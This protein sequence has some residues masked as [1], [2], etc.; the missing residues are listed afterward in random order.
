MGELAEYAYCPRAW[1]YR[2]HPPAEGPDPQ[3]LRRADAGRT[4]H[5]RRLRATRERER[6]EGRYWAALAAAAVSFAI[7]LG[8]GLWLWA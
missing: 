6:H 1:W 2:V 8:V 3:S 5:E 4:A 7:L